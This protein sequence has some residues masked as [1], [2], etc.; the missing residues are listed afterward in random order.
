MQPHVR[1]KS[2]T[3]SQYRIAELIAQGK[4]NP[5][6]AQE[7]GLS[8]YTIESHLA[9]AYKRIGVRSRV[10]LAVLMSTNPMSIKKLQT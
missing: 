2:L 8:R 5:E 1:E 3:P 4:T 9:A 10:E 7:L 6:I